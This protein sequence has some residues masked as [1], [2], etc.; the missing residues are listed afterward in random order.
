MHEIQLRCC[1]PSLHFIPGLR[2]ARL[3]KTGVADSGCDGFSSGADVNDRYTII[4]QKGASALRALAHEL[5]TEEGT[6]SY[7]DTMA[8]ELAEVFKAEEDRAA[9]EIEARQVPMQ[10]KMDRATT[11]LEAAMADASEA[12]RAFEGDLFLQLSSFRTKGFLQQA[13][14]VGA[15]LVANQAVYQAILVADDRGGSPAFALG[16]LA[17]SVGLVWFYGYRP[18]SL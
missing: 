8:Q 1:E 18:F 2:P 3:V 11:E 14:F 12:R 5:K 17:A 10:A 15:I 4:S 6:A 16:G 9:K 13:A 7:A